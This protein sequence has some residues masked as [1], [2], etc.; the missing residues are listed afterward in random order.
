MY[1]FAHTRLEPQGGSL[2]SPGA[3]LL[4]SPQALRRPATVLHAP[5]LSLE[6][7][8]RTGTPRQAPDQG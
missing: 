4:E 6:G 8:A 7:Q 2:A 3:G 1:A 5:S